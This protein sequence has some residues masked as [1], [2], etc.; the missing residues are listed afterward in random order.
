MFYK[1]LLCTDFAKY[2]SDAFKSL[3]WLKVFCRKSIINCKKMNISSGIF[4]F[5]IEIDVNLYYNY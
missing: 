2:Y 4:H 3:R 1:N 5:A